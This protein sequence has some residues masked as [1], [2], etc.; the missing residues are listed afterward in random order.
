MKEEDFIH[1]EQWEN[2]VLGRDGFFFSFFLPFFFLASL[3]RAER[4]GV[5]TDAWGAQVLGCGERTR[6]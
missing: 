4:S 1:R 5:I 3:D 2:I 6:L